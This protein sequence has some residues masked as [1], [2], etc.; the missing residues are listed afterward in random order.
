[1]ALSR[2]L[3]H[4]LTPIARRSAFAL[5]A[6]FI[7]MTIGTVGVKELA[8]K[9][10]IDSFFFMSM[11][12]TGDFFCFKVTSFTKNFRDFLFNQKESSVF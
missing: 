8:G 11:V 3:R 6:I 10:W 12:A 1:M 4:P 7:V 9:D 2:L 5:L